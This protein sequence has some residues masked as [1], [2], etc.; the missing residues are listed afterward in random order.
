MVRE[1]RVV[2][3][4]SSPWRFLYYLWLYWFIVVYVVFWLNVKYRIFCNSVLEDPRYIRHLM[5]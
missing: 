3:W 2:F 5:Y 1:W 4:I